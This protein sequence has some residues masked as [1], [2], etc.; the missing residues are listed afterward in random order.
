MQRAKAKKPTKATAKKASRKPPKRA[1]PEPAETAAPSQRRAQ[2]QIVE[3]RGVAQKGEQESEEH[4]ELKAQDR[5]ARRLETLWARAYE[6]IL[7]AN[8]DGET[9][10]EEAEKRARRGANIQFKSALPRCGSGKA[11]GIFVACV[12][13]GIAL[14]VFSGKEASHLLYA[15]QV[16]ATGRKT[17]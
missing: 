14:E 15:A 2:L 7:K 9:G 16:Q 13:A 4:D 17:A 1:E 5:E 11:R 6:A 8:N 10:S 3:T 12:A